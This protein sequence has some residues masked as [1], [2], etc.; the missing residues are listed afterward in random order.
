[1]TRRLGLLLVPAWLSVGLVSGCFPD[2]KFVCSA[3]DMCQEGERCIQA[4]CASRDGNCSTGYRYTASAGGSLADRCVA[5]LPDGGLPCTQPGDT[6]D[7]GDLCTENDVCVLDADAGALGCYGTPK[8]CG[9]STCSNGIETANVCKDGACTPTPKNC[10]PYRCAGNVCGAQCNSFDD[11][12]PGYYCFA[13]ATYCLSCADYLDRGDYIPQF[14][15][16][17]EIPGVNSSSVEDAPFMSADRLTLY[18]TSDRLGT[19]GGLDLWKASRAAASMSTAF[20]DV[21]NLTALNSDK[22]E[23]DLSIWGEDYYYFASNRGVGGKYQILRSTRSGASFSV[24]EAIVNTGSPII[25]L[26]TS[27]QSGPLVSGES[28]DRFYFATDRAQTPPG[29]YAHWSVW[30]AARDEQIFGSPQLVP[31]LGT[32]LSWFSP[33]TPAMSTSLLPGLF[34]KNA[35]V[36]WG[37]LAMTHIDPL[38]GFGWQQSV[39]TVIRAFDGTA[40][41]DLDLGESSDRPHHVAVSSDTCLLLMTDYKAD[42]KGNLA[43]AVRNGYASCANSPGGL[44]DGCCPTNQ[45]GLTDRDCPYPETKQVYMF[46]NPSYGGKPDYTETKPATPTLTFRD[47]RATASNTMELKRYETA[48]N[49]GNTGSKGIWI[50]FVDPSHGLPANPPG[51]TWVNSPT[52]LGWVSTT[53]AKHTRQIFRKRS[54]NAVTLSCRSE[55]T[56]TAD[57]SDGDNACDTKLTAVQDATG[58]SAYVVEV[59]P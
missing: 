50:G 15:A 28:G 44:D 17:E 27:D 52:T 32:N 53:P 3:D 36:P 41:A 46:S 9:P 57:C 48:G 56:F 12:A 6:C 1:M 33:S 4:R 5:E 38:T 21:E 7:D 58:K 31:Y 55:L 45:T 20:A 10:A 18:F 47:L 23:T 59:Q 54:N 16:P 49:C 43:W 40:V 51:T 22:D 29:N 2:K 42:A 19:Q 13:G 26:S 35:G 39:P 25:N 11:C 34:L 8:D 14:A 37:E 24:P 30:I